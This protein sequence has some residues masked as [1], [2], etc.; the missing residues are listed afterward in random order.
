[1]SFFQA[2]L[3]SGNVNYYVADG[4]TGNGLSQFTP[5]SIDDFLLITLADGDKVYFNRGDTFYTG[6]YDITASSVVMG[7]YGTGARPIISGAETDISGL[8]WTPLGGNVY[9]TPMVTE[10]LWVGVAGVAALNAETF[11]RIQILSR[12]S[13]TQITVS[14]SDVSG[15]SNI[16]GSYLTLK[17]NYFKMSQRVTVTAYNGAGVITIDQAIAVGTVGVPNI[18]LTLQND[19]EYFS[20]STNPQWVWRSGT[21][22][23][24]T[25]ANPSTLDIRTWDFE[26]GFKDQANTT[27]ENLELRNY[28]TAAIWS[29]DGASKLN[30][31]NIHDIKDAGVIFQQAVTGAQ[32]I[33]STIAR[34]DNVGIFMR[35]LTN[36]LIYGNTLTDI[37][38]GYNFPFQTWFNPSGAGSFGSFTQTNGAAIV[39]NI[40]RE[41]D[42]IIGSG[43]IIERNIITNTAYSGINLGVVTDDIVRYNYVEDVNNR[44]EDGGAIYTFH[45]RAYN[46]ASSTP[47]IHNNHVKTGNGTISQGIYI[48]NRTVNANI[49]HN[50]VEG[51]T[52]GILINLDTVNSTVEDNNLINNT[53]AVVF[54]AG[55]NGTLLHPDNI[56]NQFNRNVIGMYRNQKALYFDVRNDDPS[57]F[58]WNPFSGTGGADNNTYIKNG[59][60]T[61]TKNQIADSDGAGNNLDLAGLQTA[62]GEDAASVKLTENPVLFVNDTSTTS[63]EDA[64]SYYK[65]FSDVAVEAYT[66]DPYYSRI[67]NELNYSNE[68]IAASTQYFD[69]GTTADIQ[70]TNVNTFSIILRFKRNG[71]PAAVETL[72]DNRN[73]SNRGYCIQLRTDGAYQVQ[74]I[75]TTSTNRL[76]LIGTTNICDNAWHQ[77]I[78]SYNSSTNTVDLDG[79]LDS[80]T[81]SDNLTGTIASTTNLNIGRNSSGG[82]NYFT[83]FMDEIS[84][85]N[86]LQSGN[87]SIHWNG[88]RSV[89][90]ST[91]GLGSAPIHY[92]RMGLADSILDEGTGTSLDL[93]P[94]NSPT[95][96]TDAP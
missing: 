72:I 27:F 44:L 43:N 92:W 52:W 51:F 96:S 71:T 75:N 25:T 38:M 54:R 5:M 87:R 37:G 12:P 84:I 17:E 94:V 83:G 59:G 41:D 69:A 10:P 91:L 67:L 64:D 2:L 16:V 34:C 74:F 36:A 18:D 86:S 6:E 89:E 73:G 63:N 19:I 76:Q 68:F 32:V 49:H 85:W 24:K 81:I 62:Y 95:A 93:T 30:T 70:F 21:L 15:Y 13:T 11:P 9:S 1:M 35:P 33:N 31:L 66:I 57:Y 14:H 3:A 46:Y 8:T 61:T 60:T 53:Y 29:D 47:E 90:I 50:T 42:T 77:L 88:G 23:V 20:A 80:P 82:T 7:A 56:N 39:Q 48:D 22:Y 58:S 40:D 26:Y 4:G 78:V 55:D 65:D 79:V 45:Y 28:F